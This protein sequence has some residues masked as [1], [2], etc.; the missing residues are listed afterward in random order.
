MAKKDKEYD[1]FPLGP[2]EYLESMFNTFTKLNQPYLMHSDKR[3]LPAMDVFESD[4]E[5]IIILDIAQ[6]D[7]KD[8]KLSIHDNVMIIKGSRI[9]ITKFKKRHYHKMEIDYG[10]FER[11]INVPVAVNERNIKTQY[12]AGFL[13][14]RLNKIDDR[15]KGEKSINIEWDE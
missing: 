6:I 12:V 5:F 15:R 10:P 3:W 9:E 1:G 13:E 11:R 7:P 2:G 14:I 4:D 8:I